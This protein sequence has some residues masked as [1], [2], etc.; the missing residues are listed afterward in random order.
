M[1]VVPD[2]EGKNVAFGQGTAHRSETTIVLEAVP[3]TESIFLV[4]TKLFGDRVVIG[5]YAREVGGRVGN[6]LAILNKN[7][8]NVDKSTG[9]RVVVGDELCDDGH[10]L[11]GID[12]LARTVKA[13]DTLTV[14]VEVTAV[15]IA[16]SVVTLGG[17]VALRTTAAVVSTIVVGLARMRGIG[18]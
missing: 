8:P 10:L 18:F 7:A 13:F 2:G 16:N 3:V 6:D 5:H 14:W 12:S 4:G 17:G 11:V 1:M 15:G 9:R